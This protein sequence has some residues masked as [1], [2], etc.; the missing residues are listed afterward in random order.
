MQTT[1][2]FRTKNIP[3]LSTLVGNGH[4]WGRT[5]SLWSPDLRERWAD[6]P[7]CD[8][9]LRRAQS[10][11]KMCQNC[12]GCNRWRLLWWYEGLSSE[13]SLEENLRMW[14]GYGNEWKTNWIMM[15]FVSLMTNHK[16]DNRDQ[17]CI[18]DVHRIRCDTQRRID[19][20]WLWIICDYLKSNHDISI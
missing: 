17:I 8:I 1:H 15:R 3:F 18:R 5:G 10:F 16:K 12:R 19:K 4:S 11:C 14:I 6:R 13:C 7:S 20:K 9:P 2:S